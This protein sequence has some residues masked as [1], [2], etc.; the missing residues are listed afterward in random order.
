MSR[1]LEILEQM[2][3]L[4]NRLTEIV[5]EMQKRSKSLKGM[6]EQRLPSR[7]SRNTR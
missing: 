7:P 6:G 2:V 3:I 5:D 1:R 4:A